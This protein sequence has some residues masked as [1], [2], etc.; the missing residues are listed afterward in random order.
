MKNLE[1]LTNLKELNLANNTITRL[2]KT[3]FQGLD[4]LE[5][6]NLAGNPIYSPLD[7]KAL[8]VLPSLRSLTFMDEDY[9]PVPLS[10]MKNYQFV[11]I[12]ELPQ[13]ETL[14]QMEL[15]DEMKT[16]VNQ[17]ISEKKMYFITI[18]YEED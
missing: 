2:Y 9:N 10:N 12:H 15:T 8:T 5:S 3:S 17:V 11:F 13:L 1:T 6:L 14:D 7:V 18:F 16:R 4:S